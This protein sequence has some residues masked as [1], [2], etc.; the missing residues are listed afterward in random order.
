MNL[1]QGNLLF[2]RRAWLERRQYVKTKLRGGSGAQTNRKRNQR[3]IKNI[4]SYSL[5]QVRG[6]GTQLGLAQ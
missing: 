1:K 2:W 4:H 6:A 5:S 3:K